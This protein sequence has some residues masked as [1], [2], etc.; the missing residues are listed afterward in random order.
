MVRVHERRRRG[1]SLRVA[2]SRLARWRGRGRVGRRD[3]DGRGPLG[4]EPTLS[5]GRLAIVGV[6]GRQAAGRNRGLI[7]RKREE[8]S[9]GQSA[10]AAQ[11]VCVLLNVGD[12]Q[13]MSQGRSLRYISQGR[14]GRKKGSQARTGGRSPS[15]LS[16]SEVQPNR[17]FLRAG[18]PPPPPAL[19]YY[20]RS[21]AQAEGQDRAGSSSLPSLPFPARLLAW[22]L[23]AGRTP[24]AQ[25][26][27]D[28]STPFTPGP[29]EAAGRDSAERAREGRGGEES[30]NRRPADISGE[31]GILSPMA[32][33]KNVRA[34]EGETL[35][36]DSA[37]ARSREDGGLEQAGRARGVGKPRGWAGEREDG[38][39][40]A[41]REGGKEAAMRWGRAAR[42]GRGNGVSLGSVSA[43]AQVKG[44]EEPKAAIGLLLPA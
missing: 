34:S 24:P 17:P 43:R 31:Q 14:R 11:N 9:G 42:P 5:D 10:L 20:E 4:E 23:L 18:P 44:G 40:W 22:C 26:L 3:E 36:P 38:K 37:T 13:P 21:N 1:P 8:G 28:I 30:R 19:R 7:V 6:Q 27:G 32:E 16:V 33:G 35:S 15:F 12:A 29:A 39:R 41:W 2:W 25:S